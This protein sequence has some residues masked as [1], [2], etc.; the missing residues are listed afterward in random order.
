MII[1]RSRP[2]SIAWIKRDNADVAC[3][4][5]TIFIAHLL[6]EDLIMNL[7]AYKL[8]MQR[9]DSEFDLPQYIV[10]GLIREIH[11]NWGRLPTDEQRRYK[12]L[13]AAVLTRIEAIVR[14]T[15]GIGMGH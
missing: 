6:A 3:D 8:A 9:I 4:N 5:S 2:C 1:S 11:A 14:E 15:F 12:H 13:P 10:S 7:D